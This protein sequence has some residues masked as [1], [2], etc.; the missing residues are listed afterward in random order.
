M[1]EII[2]CFRRQRLL[3]H[4]NTSGK[5]VAFKEQLKYSVVKIVREKY[6][7]TTNFQDSNELQVCRYKSGF[8]FF[9][10]RLVAEVENPGFID[11]IALT[12]WLVS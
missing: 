8:R 4:L 11:I 12:L 6:L 3:Y 10:V 1:P 5:Y 7:K 9:V 2:V